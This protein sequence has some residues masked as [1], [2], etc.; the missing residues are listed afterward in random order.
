MPRHVTWREMADD[1][2]SSNWGQQGESATTEN[3][4]NNDGRI[5]MILLLDIARSLR[6][7]RC[8]NFTDMPRRLER[9]RL[10]TEGMRRDMKARSRRR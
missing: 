9:V 1:L 5:Q 4:I 7:L 6:I 8:S 2:I 3:K 10:A